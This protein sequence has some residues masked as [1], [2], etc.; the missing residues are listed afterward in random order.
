LEPQNVETQISILISEGRIEEAIEK[1]DNDYSL[2]SFALN[3][4]LKEKQ[5]K[6]GV[7]IVKKILDLNP[8]DVDAH[9]NYGMMLFTLNRFSEAECEF[10]KGLNTEDNK[11]RS[12]ILTSLGYMLEKVN[13]YEDAQSKYEEAIRNNSENIQALEN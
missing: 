5:P 2:L 9:E 11:K 4:F 12:E 10:Y 13:R 3:Y 6:Y 1:A 8:Q 7:I